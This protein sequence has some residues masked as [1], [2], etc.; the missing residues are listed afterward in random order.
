[1]PYLPE[2]FAN[3]CV[4]SLETD[5]RSEERPFVC[6]RAR[7]RVEERASLLNI[8]LRLLN[9]FVLLRRRE[10]EVQRHH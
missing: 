10:L 7:A 2:C 4:F 8:I 5:G 6:V 3:V 1:M 9:L